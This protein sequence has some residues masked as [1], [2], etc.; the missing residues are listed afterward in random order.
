MPAGADKLAQ[1]RH[2]GYLNLETF[3]RSGAAVRTPVWFAEH[4]GALYVY[5]HATAGKVKRIQRNP[6]V[7]I[8]PCGPR[9][10]PRGMWVQ[11]TARIEGAAGRELGERL[12]RKKY[13][14]QKA[15]GDFFAGLRHQGRVVFTLHPD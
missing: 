11:A 1:F 9:G 7:R 3:R 14:W 4:G 8:V 13:G 12:L 5:T 2:Q 6:R 15:I 10:K